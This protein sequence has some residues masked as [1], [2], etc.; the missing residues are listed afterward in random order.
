MVISKRVQRRPDIV[1]EA[2]LCAG[3]SLSR[4]PIRRAGEGCAPRAPHGKAVGRQGRTGRSAGATSRRRLRNHLHGGGRI[5]RGRGW[6]TDHKRGRNIYPPL[7][8]GVL[9]GGLP[10]PRPPTTLSR[11]R[12]GD[13]AVRGK[14]TPDAPLARWC[15]SERRQSARLSSPR[16]GQLPNYCAI[17]TSGQ[18]PLGLGRLIVRTRRYGMSCGWQT[19][20]QIERLDDT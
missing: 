18:V 9:R 16:R 19:F 13:V 15:G 6:R 11:L 8:G 20:A 5:T 1:S 10:T 7:A 3:R 17:S 4:A 14:L 2:G 12:E